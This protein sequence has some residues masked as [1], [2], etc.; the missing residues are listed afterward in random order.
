MSDQKKE[1]NNLT[2]EKERLE[3]DVT[4]FKNLLDA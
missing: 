2:H 4:E 3:E 1:I